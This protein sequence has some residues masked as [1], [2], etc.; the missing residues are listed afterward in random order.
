MARNIITN[1]ELEQFKRIAIKKKVD[2]MEL[3]LIGSN[4]YRYNMQEVGAKV[5]G[6]A[7]YS[8]TVSLIHRCYNFAGQNGRMYC[9]G[10]K[11]E[12]TYGYR[13]TRKDIE[14]FVAK[15]PNGTFNNG[16]T[17]EDFLKKRA[18]SIQ[19]ASA[20]KTTYKPAPVHKSPVQC[21]P[22]PQFNYANTEDNEDSNMEA[23]FRLYL[24][25]SGVLGAI[26]LIVMLLS[27]NLFAHLKFALIIL[28]YAIGAFKAAKL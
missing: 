21:I 18:S 3:Y 7:N 15:Y 26:I 4:G 23:Q 19:R 24:R 11:F 5:F 16:V 9:N 27:G 13:V 6:D 12:Q 17:F 25:M 2:S 1:D 22:Q 8:Y 14:A 20:P 10:C 28:I